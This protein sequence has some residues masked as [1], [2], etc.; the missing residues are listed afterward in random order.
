MFTSIKICC[1]TMRSNHR[2]LKDAL[3]VVFNI[4]PIRYYFYPTYIE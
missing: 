3:D 1:L 2:I 4:V